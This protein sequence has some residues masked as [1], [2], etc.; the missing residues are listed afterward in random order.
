[1]APLTFHRIGSFGLPLLLVSSTLHLL[2]PISFNENG[3]DNFYRSPKPERRYCM[4]TRDLIPKSN[5]WFPT[6]E[7]FPHTLEWYADCWNWIQEQGGD[8]GPGVD[9]GFIVDESVN[10]KM[11]KKYWNRAF[12]PAMQWPIEVLNNSSMVL[13]YNK[14]TTKYYQG[15]W[16]QRESSC[17]SFRE[18]MWKNLD[19]KPRKSSKKNKRI[20]IVNR[21][22]SR[23]IA[24][25]DILMQKLH[26][27]YPDADIHLRAIDSEYT[28][29]NSDDSLEAQAKWFADKDLVILAH[30]AAMSNAVFMRPGSSLLELYPSNYFNDMFWLL[31]EQCGIHHD[32]YYDG[33]NK[34]KRGK[35]TEKQA[36][37]E[38]DENWKDRMKNKKK[39]IHFRWK[40]VDHIIYHLLKESLSKK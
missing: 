39:D 13:E 18:R 33:S 8:P 25:I 21:N 19:V 20:G 26:K 27:K 22:E 11:H 23:A 37:A 36:R 3:F 38:T 40:D 32:W 7:H 15:G 5:K 16:F 14:M 34:K 12:F 28:L 9:G 10:K 2:V 35:Y 4:L 1:M 17:S 6:I 30:G 29:T 31:M 24:D